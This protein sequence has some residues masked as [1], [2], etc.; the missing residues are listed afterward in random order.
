VRSESIGNEMTSQS[1]VANGWQ[2]PR[3][4]SQATVVDLVDLYFE[5]VY[6][7]FPFFHQTSF[8]R[9]ISRGEYTTNKTLFA[10]TMA[11]CA[12][13]SGR[14]RDGA[15]FNPH[16]DTSSL[17]DPPSEA[18][19]DESAR[20]LDQIG[21]VSDLNVMRAHA[22]L[23][24]TAIQYGKIRELHRQIGAYHTIV[25]MDALHDEGNW[26]RDIGL[27]ETE[28]RRR[29]FWS[30]YTLDIYS[31]I[32][33]GGVIRSRENQSR[34][35]YPRAVDD[36]SLSNMAAFTSS[37]SPESFA[38]GQVSDPHWMVG[39]NFV[40]DLYRVLEHLMAQFRDQQ[41]SRLR[42][43]FHG[44]NPVSQSVVIRNVLEIYLALP[45]CFQETHPMSYDVKQDRFGFQAAN[46][47]A[48]VQLL[49]MVLFSTAGASIAERCQIA[50]EVV[51]SFIAIPASYL[52]AISIPL[53]FHLGG[54][55]QVLTMALEGPLS[56][57]D[58]N[59]V[60]SVIMTMAR[61]L[62]NLE[63]VHSSAGA[64]ERL[65][66]QVVRIDEYM[67]SQRRTTR[68]QHWNDDGTSTERHSTESTE[69]GDGPQLATYT[70]FEDVSELSP[71]QLP[72]E[73]LGDFSQIF[74]FGQA[75]I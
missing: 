8:V 56:E 4:A 70:D 57:V 39:W 18:F 11:V 20:Q 38:S 55:G 42:E 54:I 44:E 66:S 64:S 34:V 37:Q 35:S 2:A 23:A 1:S 5:V 49:R 50:D 28:E 7:I 75:I 17:Q 72:P 63:S 14:V 45:K 73:L 46:I 71:F 59:S 13:V 9:R 58:Y 6:P 25:A 52:K 47:I 65:R 29:L 33:W 15:V 51:N 22:I 31:S 62:S 61:L 32:V 21:L 16:W 53:L 67:A 74:D 3:I 41:S 27:V 26:P 60:R 68:S 10:A 24:I 36:S 43:I 12:L 30:I 19:Y 69:P 40:T 48:T